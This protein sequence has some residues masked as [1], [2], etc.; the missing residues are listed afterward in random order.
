M[1]TNGGLDTPSNSRTARIEIFL[2]FSPD[3]KILSGVPARRGVDTLSFPDEPVEHVLVGLPLL[4]M[5]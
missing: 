1:K 5:S 2:F 3:V 4:E